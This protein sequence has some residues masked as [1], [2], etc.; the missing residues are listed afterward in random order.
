MHL[1]GVDLNLFVVFETIYAQRNLTRAS[2]ILNIT[3]PAV[4][5]ALARLR[6]AYGDPLFVRVGRTMT[7]SPLA[8][9]LIGPVRG[10]LRQLRTSIE[11]GRS[12]DPLTSE[13]VFN[14]CVRDNACTELMPSLMARLAVDAPG[15][16]VHCQEVDRREIAAELA[17]AR[18]D[19]AIDIPEVARSE[20]NSLPLFTDRYVCVLRRDHPK[21]ARALDLP[22]FLAMNHIMVS[23]RRSGRGFVD[24]ALAR[25]G[26]Q[27]NSFLRLTHFQ[28]AFHAVMNTDM[29]L[30]APLSLARKYDVAIK[31]L[32]FPVPV[33][34]AFLYWHRN[35][36]SDPANI[37][38]R[39]A[40]AAI[41][42]GN[43]NRVAKTD[44]PGFGTSI[45]AS[46]FT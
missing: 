37:W 11:Q 16:R 15:V 39:Q 20:L 46:E 38:M 8:H 27:T 14:I 21:A 24:I 32:P 30:S 40:I 45:D 1:S 33:L 44:L 43:L 17:S 6:A 22:E 13:K 25:L 7:P 19:L 41:D 26:H 12:F 42:N 34:E 5:N 35:A 9:N 28:P 23:G 2:E 18:L 4:S 10:A 31:E 36:D 29:V 3:Q